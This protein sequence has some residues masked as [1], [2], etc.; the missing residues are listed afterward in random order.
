MRRAAERPEEARAA[1]AKTRGWS[2]KSTQIANATS[3]RRRSDRLDE[4]Q[5]DGEDEHAGDGR[6]PGLE[7]DRGEHDAVVGHSPTRRTAT[8]RAAGVQTPPGMYFASIETISACRRDQVRQPD[9]VRAQDP[10]PA[11]D[12]EQ[13][14][15][16]QASEASVR[17]VEVR[18]AD[19]R[20]G[21]GPR[22]RAPRTR[23]TRAARAAPHLEG[24]D[25][26][27]V[28]RDAPE[29]ASQPAAPALVRFGASGTHR[30]PN[31]PGPH[32]F[33]SRRRA[34]PAARASAC[35]RH[36]R[37]HLGDPVGQ[38]VARRGGDG[39][40]QRPVGGRRVELALERRPAPSGA[41][42]AR[43]RLHLA[44]AICRIGRT[45]SSWPTMPAALPMRPPRTR[46][47]SVSTLTTMRLPAAK[48]SL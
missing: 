39:D 25:E 21:L 12:E 14:V 32:T 41:A 2:R 8:T 3:G 4:R 33:R 22:R 35:G 24:D 40:A 16:A 42:H 6:E 15:G 37:D 11:D 18:V 13:V 1:G 29:E 10:H 20:P 26:A 7:R 47:S 9:A 36:A 38:V 23:G 30:R 17:S 31:A 28:G 45:E 43:Q 44:V 27:A 46:Y 34:S 5:A 19:A 48:R